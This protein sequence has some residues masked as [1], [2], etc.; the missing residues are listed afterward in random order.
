MSCGFEKKQEWPFGYG[1]IKIQNCWLLAVA[2]ASN[3]A[4]Y[5]TATRHRQALA[6]NCSIHQLEVAVYNPVVVL[7]R[8]FL[9]A[10]YH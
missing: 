10:P 7:K 9:F 2:D 3:K 4:N 5:V 1:I 6:Q 8:P